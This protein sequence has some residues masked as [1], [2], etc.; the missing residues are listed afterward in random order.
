M[1][2]LV[3]TIVTGGMLLFGTAAFA[4]TLDEARATI[5]KEAM[6]RKLDAKDRSQATATLRRLVDKGVPVEHAFRVVDA[7][8][9]QGMN[10]RDLAEVAGSIESTGPG[11]RK[12]A[13]AA[14]ADAI[15]HRY[16]AH[17]TVQMMNAFGKTVAA[18]APA[19]G[20]SWVMSRGI[21]KG[22]GATRITAAMHAYS[23][24]IRSGTPPDKA[25]A[26]AD[27]AMDRDKTRQQDRDMSRDRDRTSGGSGMDH[28]SGPGA[29]AG[30][31]MG[32]SRR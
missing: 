23:R 21:D 28:G 4:L 26:N 27:R 32:G 9:N 31:G 20:T 18:G 10:G 11:A 24:E 16:T 22:T 5:D 19:E 7:A 12:D 15:H 3:T 14:A 30:P 1:N 13:A 8:I 17:E 2:K 29:G 25:A 6:E